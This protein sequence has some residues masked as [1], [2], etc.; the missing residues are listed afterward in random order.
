V[1]PIAFQFGALT[2]TW[3]GVMVAM[4]FLIGLWAASRR[5]P[6]GGIQAERVLDLGPW[7]IIGGI[8]GARLLYV[9]TF[10]HEQFAG[11]PLA[12]VLMVWRGGLVFYGGFIG[13]ALA[14]VLYAGLKKIALWKLAD[15]LAPSIALGA[16]FG[17][18]GCFLN[19]CCYGRQCTLPWAVHFPQGHETY[20][21]AVHPTQLYDAAL[22]LT[23]F[24]ALSWVYR[25]RKFDGQVFATFLCG[26]AVFRFLVEIF[27][28][29]Y[30]AY[31]HYLG[32]WATPAQV[33]SLGIFAVGIVLW[34]LLP[35]RGSQSAPGAGFS[36]EGADKA[37][38][39]DKA[40]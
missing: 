11:R 32:G 34:R 18:V 7:L 22:S 30:P 6:E 36:R 25:R 13:A 38:T 5:A 39:A 17:R 33:V 12:E 24:A 19:G 28:G 4:A 16:A 23:L 35:R 3:Y 9:I 40:K 26:Y 21:N 10:W 37:P 29:D 14:C 15:V 2:I 8:V 20:P 31:Q 1:H 27:R